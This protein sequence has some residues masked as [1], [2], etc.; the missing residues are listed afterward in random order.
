[1][2]I[3]YHAV[4]LLLLAGAASA[5]DRRQISEPVIPPACSALV[6][7]KF[8]GGDRKMAA[9]DEDRADTARIQRALDQCPAG[10][11]VQLKTGQGTNAFLTGP[12]A[13][14]QGVTLLVD[15]GVTLYA[16]RRG[17]DYDYP[18]ASGVCGTL[19][20]AEQGA[21]KAHGNVLP[22]KPAGCRPLISVS[23]VSKA[24]V[25]G[26][27]VIDG[28]GD[29]QLL[30]QP[31]SWWQMARKAEPGD[32]RLYSTRL[33]VAK[34]A[35]GF[36]LY[37]IALHNSPNFH[38]T[39]NNTDGFTAWGVHVQ[40]PTVHGTDARNTDGI[41]PGGSTNVT[42]AH[43]WIDTDDDNVAIKT[44][45]TYAS[46]LHNHFYNGHGMSIG[47]ETTSGVSHLLVDDL[48]E[49]H[50]T[51][52]IR[53]K[54]NVTRGGPVHDLV[55]QHVCM[56]DV[57]VPIAISPWYIGQTIEPF[58]DPG[59]EGRLIP[60][61]K[62]ITLRDLTSVTPGDVL[63]AGASDA[64]RT[65]VTLENVHV[66]GVKGE[67]LHMR[68][69]DITD[70]GTSMPLAAVKD[71]TVKVG[72]GKPVP[73]P[74]YSCDGKFV[75]MRPTA[76]A[77]DLLNGRDFSGWEVVTAAPATAP[78]LT[79]LA[80]GV[81]GVSGAPTGYFATT[82]RYENFRLHAEWRW[83]DKPGNGGI[84]VHVGDPPKT[85]PWPLSV[86]VQT[87]YQFVGDALPMAGAQFAEQLTSAPGAATPIRAH[88]AADSER[89][90]GEWNS[91]DIVSQDG[92]LEVRINGVLQNALS[93]LQPKA[94]RVGFQLEGTPYQ[95]RN[96]VLTPA[97]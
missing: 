24:A 89:P 61:Y 56:R 92:T 74:A 96:V 55:Y 82:G 42:I 45:V 11:A 66:N 77:A 93:G 54:S 49:D 36:I 35:D 3:N 83:T 21:A 7:D 68:Y 44:G 63:I 94:G 26:E 43:S 10:Q 41:D 69:A 91:A 17:S 23:Q 51:S 76:A 46:V 20:H 78:V 14:R 1:M 47:S 85:G 8:V 71:K 88:I 16:S 87:K 33:I 34:E 84:L 67:Q 70:A 12:I 72:A 73:G 50:T 90:L 38:V 60:D 64:H 2:R 97:P 22:R 29:M 4:F 80:D 25:M 57:K 53:I 15:K 28:R 86:Q 58:A 37:K 31:M 13:L 9:A 75:P 59:Y 95:L 81:I 32:L 79:R 30:G 18:M 65:G 40:S 52:G 19:V 5:Q 27:G 6:A 48:V 39:V 62:A